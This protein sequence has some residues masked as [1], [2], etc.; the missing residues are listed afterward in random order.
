MVSGR[1]PSR[2]LETL[3]PISRR[4]LTPQ[5]LVAGMA[6]GPLVASGAARWLG[7]SGMAFTALSVAQRQDGAIVRTLHPVTQL[8]PGLE[9][10]LGSLALANDDPLSCLGLAAD[11]TLVMGIVNVTP[12]SFS[13]GGRFEGAAGIA[14]GRALV[15][16]GADL[17]D[18]GGE[19]TRPGAAAVPVAEEIARVVPVI[20]GLAPLGV[21]ISIDSR[22][23]E[24]M[25]AAL[26]AGA[27]LVNDVAALGFDPAARALVAQRRVPVILM[28]AQGE[29]ATMQVD[30]RYDD[31]LLDVFD[32]FMARIAWCQAGGIDPAQI[33]IDP[34][35]GFGK[36]VA[37]NLA[38]IE[39]LALFHGLGRPILLGASRKSFIGK[40]SSG[41]GAEHRLGGSVAVALAGA[42]RG[43]R[44]VR[45]HDVAETVQALRLAKAVALAGTPQG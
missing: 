1:S 20:A 41:E 22:K 16:A 28:H 39:S 11:R 17:L 42:A 10:Q 3:A 21:P 35:I 26:D 25:A 40:L 2:E 29:P 34:G 8:P 13:D 6:A 38:L 45:V 33:V 37:H 19:S 12:D 18:I 31:V 15:A 14:H 24:V 30:P 44:L 32:W 43:A 7:G 23:A 36:T 9:E 4:Y 5:G 27:H